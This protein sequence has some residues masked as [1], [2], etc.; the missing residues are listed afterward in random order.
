MWHFDW[1]AWYYDCM[2]IK[3]VQELC[4]IGERPR[5]SEFHQNEVYGIVVTRTKKL[6]QSI[7]TK[8]RCSK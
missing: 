6:G 5:A 8:L 7:S 3:Y 2:C 1:A 4:R